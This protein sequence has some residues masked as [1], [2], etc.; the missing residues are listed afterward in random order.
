[1]RGAAAAATAIGA[2]AFAGS[3]LAANTG[4]IAVSQAGT[5]TT[6]HVSIPKET[7][8]IAALTIIV[9]A[10][11][12][13][14]LGQAPGTQ[15]GTI[16]SAAA[17]SYDTNLTLP[18][19]GL[20][21]V[22]DPADA[23]VAAAAAAC[24]PGETPAAVWMLNLQVSGQS[25]AVPMFVTPTTA[26]QQAIGAGPDKLTTCLPPPDVPPG[27]PGRAAFG[28]QLLDALFTVNGIFT[29]PSAA[30]AI[31]WE[32]LMTPYNPGAGTPNLAGTFET[33]G[34]ISPVPVKLTAKVNRKK[35]VAVLTARITGG[36]VPVSAVT[37]FR[38]PAPRK[39]KA[40]VVGKAPSGVWRRTVKVRGKKPVYFQV[41]FRGGEA[42]VTSLACQQPLPATVAP[43]GCVSATLAPWTATSNVVRVKP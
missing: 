5:A 28:A 23:A 12:G 38:G 7:N 15:I 32:A 1:L 22:A 29:P 27:T 31:V 21:V 37:M 39:L 33:R 36:S 26:D 11:Y 13:V 30:G 41:R 14:T 6:I 40:A 3:A 43:A 2:L 34:V 18:L 20:V 25:L 24:V 16:P 10:G 35:H 17:F 19:S 42:D 4:T 9:P 8:P